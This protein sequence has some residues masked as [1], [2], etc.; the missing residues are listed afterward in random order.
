VHAVA[1]VGVAP[2]GSEHEELAANGLEDLRQDDLDGDAGLGR[3]AVDGD[4][5][6]LERFLRESLDERP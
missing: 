5:S 2:L 6:H 3:H 4:G 1:D